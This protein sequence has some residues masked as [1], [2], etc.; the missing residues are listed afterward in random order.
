MLCGTKREAHTALDH[1]LNRARWVNLHRKE[2]VESV[3]LGRVLVSMRRRGKADV[4]VRCRW[5]IAS[6][7]RKET[8]L[9]ELLAERIRQVVGGV[10]GLSIAR[11]K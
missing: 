3:D 8:R 11:A 2:V 6:V 4:L 5:A 9:V 1:L 10:G 7:G